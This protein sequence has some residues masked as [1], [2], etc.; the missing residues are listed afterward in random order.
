MKLCFF[1]VQFASRRLKHFMFKVTNGKVEKISPI[2]GRHSSS[3]RDDD[4][5]LP[6]SDE[7]VRSF[8]EEEKED[9]TNPEPSSRSEVDPNGYRFEKSFV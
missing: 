6:F 5:A 7:V 2:F 9:W 4:E 3:K 8:E 1:Q